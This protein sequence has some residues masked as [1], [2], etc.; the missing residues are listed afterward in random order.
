[1]KIEDKSKEDSKRNEID[2]DKLRRLKD[3]SYFENL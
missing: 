2:E 1:M 3:V